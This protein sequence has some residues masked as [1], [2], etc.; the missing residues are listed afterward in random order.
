MP[1]RDTSQPAPAARDNT[2]RA[3][4]AGGTDAELAARG[5]ELR[6]SGLTD[7]QVRHE[8]QGEGFKLSA[9]QAWLKGSSEPAEAPTDGPPAGDGKTTTGGPTSPSSGGGSG[10]GGRVLFTGSSAGVL[11]AIVAYPAGIAFITGGPKGLRRWFLAKFLNQTSSDAGIGRSLRLGAD[12]AA[13]AGAD[14]SGATAAQPRSSRVI[15]TA[16]A[17]PA[18]VVTSFTRP[19]SKGSAMSNAA[20]HGK[21]GARGTNLV[22]VRAGGQ[23]FRVNKL[24]APK[25][26]AL[27][28]DLIAHGYHPHSISGYSPRKIAGTNEWSNHAYG[29]AIDIDPGKNKRY[30]TAKGG[31]HAIPDALARAAAHRHGLQ[32]GGDYHHSKDYMHFEVTDGPAS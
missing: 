13:Q 11:L 22:T 15:G 30:G 24:A 18:A 5:A 25:F 6:A 16:Y 9:I 3:A 26:E 4:K 8:L 19:T 21:Y 31:P 32:W 14:P 23:S 12:A 2:R 20:A 28:N 27:V 7:A 29:L 10:G 1:K 17:N